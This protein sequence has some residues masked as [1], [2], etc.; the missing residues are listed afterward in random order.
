MI[1]VPSEMLNQSTP[2][3]ALFDA[4]LY[5]HRSL[6]PVGF[7]VLMGCVAAVSFAAGLFFF[8]AGA[9]PIVG[10][11]GLDVLLIYAAFK[12]SYRAARLTETI[13]LTENELSVSRTD[14]RGRVISWTFQP[15]W[16]RVALEEKAE[17][18]SR[19]VLSSHGRHVALGDFLVHDER[20]ALAD[21]LRGALATL[22]NQRSAPD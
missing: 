15:F 22:K 17:R 6:G 9:W 13:A 5:P 11:L 21:A 19:L 14:P 2:A 3:P 1:D 10:F 8:L 7:A 18:D 4:V 16:V 20:V 12:F